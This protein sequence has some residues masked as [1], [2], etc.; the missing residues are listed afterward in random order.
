MLKIVFLLVSV[1]VAV[2]A[3]SQL[4]DLS[5]FF[6]LCIVQYIDHSLPFLP[7]K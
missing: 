4:A 5:G 3:A 1:A 6:S 7:F 2:S